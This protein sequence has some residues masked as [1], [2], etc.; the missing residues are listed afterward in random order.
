MAPTVSFSQDTEDLPV[1]GSGG[2][3]DSALVNVGFFFWWVGLL[4]IQVLS[5]ICCGLLYFCKPPKII[6]FELDG[7][8]DFVK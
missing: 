7:Y 6:V 4:F 2:R 3:M 8:R 5:V 1:F